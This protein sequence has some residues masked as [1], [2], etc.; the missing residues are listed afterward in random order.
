MTT[1]VGLVQN[2]RQKQCKKPGWRCVQK[3]LAE[4]A[5]S[6]GMSEQVLNGTFPHLKS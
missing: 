5:T 1:E 4:E 2:V 3:Q 6:V